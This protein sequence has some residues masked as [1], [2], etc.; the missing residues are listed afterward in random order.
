MTQFD[1]EAGSRLYYFIKYKILG[2]LGLLIFLLFVY[3]AYS[4]RGS[5]PPWPNS[6]IA[7]LFVSL[8]MM[9]VV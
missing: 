2:F 1:I 8:A 6:A 4:V 9:Y 7:M 3:F 5:P